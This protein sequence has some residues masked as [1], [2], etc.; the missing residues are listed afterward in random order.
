[1]LT[2]T[3]RTG[4]YNLGPVAKIP[5][6]E[7][8]TF[9]VGRLDVAVFRARGGEVFAT[10]ARCPHRVGPLADGLLGA[11]RVICPLHG[12]TFDLVTGQSVGNV[13]E[14]LTTYSIR[15]DEAGDVL[16]NLGV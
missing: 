3:L 6:G 4:T 16:L 15:I 5:P 8:R 2:T 13:C 11:S 12:Y 1:M 7:G 14:A 10:Q 9:R